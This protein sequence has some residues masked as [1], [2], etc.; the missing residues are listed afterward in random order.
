MVML[1]VGRAIRVNLSSR[2]TIVTRRLL[3]SSWPACLVLAASVCPPLARADDAINT[4]RPDTVESSEVVGKGRFQIETSIASERNHADGV[5]TRAYTTPTLL[6][7]GVADDWELRLETDGGVWAKS[8]DDLTGVSHTDHG[9]ADVSLG[10]KWH[11][12][13]GDEAAGRPSMGWLLHADVPSGTQAFHGNSVRPSL[14]FVAE[15]DLPRD[16]SL[17]V[18][19]GVVYDKTDAGHRY[20]AGILAAVLG[21]QITDQLRVFVEVA[22]QQITARGNGGSQVT[23]DTGV[24]Y[25]L[26]QSVQIDF[27]V[28]QALNSRTPD[29]TWTSGLSIKF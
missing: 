6:R 19:P 15:W 27:A 16:W 17:G 5:K 12:L 22:A 25:R 28:N 7:Y 26:T 21:K 14:R 9:F 10:V 3:P 23:F 1:V 8:T 18:M 2:D 4:D 11:M 24:S 13:D 29:F 20:T